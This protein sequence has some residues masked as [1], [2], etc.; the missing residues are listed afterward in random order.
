M[1]S[2]VVMM[3]EYARQTLD[4]ADQTVLL[5]RAAAALASRHVDPVAVELPTGVEARI[6][7]RPVPGEVG[8]ASGVVHVKLLEPSSRRLDTRTPARMYLPGLVGSGPLWLR[9][10][11]RVDAAQE[12][13]RM[14]RA[15]RRAGRRQAG[16]TPGGALPAQPG[17]ALPGGGRRRG[18]RCA[19]ARRGTP[20]IARRRRQP[21]DPPRRPAGRPAAAGVDRGGAGGPGRGPAPVVCG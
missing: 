9:G 11:H 10:C 20:G 12:V 2:D 19:V 15:R 14:A 13:R 16:R 21:R 6:Y 3:N 17:R 4:P 5:G 8:L 7:C 1:N 18:H